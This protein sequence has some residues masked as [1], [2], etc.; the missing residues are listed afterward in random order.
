MVKKKYILR[1]VLVVICML[2]VSGQFGRLTFYSSQ[3]HMYA[4]ELGMIFLLILLAYLYR[5]RGI[6]FIAKKMTLVAIFFVY[7]LCI[8]LFQVTEFSLITNTI[9]LLYV[10]RM[11]LYVLFFTYL[12]LYFSDN[13]D[14]A[15]FLVRYLPVFFCVILLVSFLQYFVFPDLRF[16]SS[17]GWDPHKHRMTG[18]FLEPA[19][20]SAI[21]GIIGY[22]SL[23][24]MNKS[25]LYSVIPIISV[26][27][28]FLTVS[29]AGIIA[30]II[31]FGAFL[32]RNTIIS[33]VLPPG[34]RSV[35]GGTGIGII[36]RG[37]PRYLYILSVLIPLCIIGITIFLAGRQG[38]GAN[39][40]RT[41]TIETRI[42]NYS[43]AFQ[44]WK[45]YP[46]FGI[47]YNR[48]SAVK[49]RFDFPERT[50]LEIQNARSSFHSSYL[51]ILVTTGVI[52]LTF[53]LLLLV[54]LARLSEFHLV[55]VGYLAV[56]AIFDNI[57]LHPFILFLFFMCSII[58]LIIP[59]F[60]RL[61]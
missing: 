1:L 15:I 50:S 9:S 11:I 22:F 46:I 37:Y 56:F 51:I 55:S 48:I 4:Y 34:Q 61:R 47:G 23:L 30:F 59:P 28:I 29:R 35:K 52:G 57:L 42:E 32:L 44:I 20:A 27:S 25:Y 33:N 24:N 17:Y 49:E 14:E 60:H 6:V 16:L 5:L 58:G 40:L 26:V 2:F 3:A 10:G 19:F 8:F 36:K 13:P 41:S 45:H 12:Y 7:V 39:I 21:F 53:F 54:F 18:V 38:E 43:E 31:S